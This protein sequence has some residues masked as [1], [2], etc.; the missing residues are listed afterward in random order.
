MHVEAL[1]N[2]GPLSGTSTTKT[3]SSA[4]AQG[5]KR[6]LMIHAASYKTRQLMVGKPKADALATGFCAHLV[7]L[8][9]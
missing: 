4:F 5:T 6:L 2:E 8:R 1:S 3:C 9:C 7:M